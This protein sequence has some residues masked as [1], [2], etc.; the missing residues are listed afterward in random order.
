M[1]DI[2]Y[3]LNFSRQ[4]IDQLTI[5]KKDRERKEIAMETKE[6]L[7]RGGKIQIVPSSN[8]SDYVPAARDFHL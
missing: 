5:E 1:S 4:P 2:T 8:R 7:A 6:F 3:R